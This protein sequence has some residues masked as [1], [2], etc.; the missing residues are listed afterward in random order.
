M[1]RH[2]PSPPDSK[3]RPHWTTLVVWQLDAGVMEAA[4]GEVVA[5]ALDRWRHGAARGLCFV[6]TVGSNRAVKS[7][8]VDWTDFPDELT[9]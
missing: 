8:D 4:S 7:E 9:R 5:G 1:T 3:R 2:D 6:T